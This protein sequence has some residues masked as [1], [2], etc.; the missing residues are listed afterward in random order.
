MRETTRFPSL[1]LSKAPFLVATVVPCLLPSAKVMSETLASSNR[2]T[3]KS[4]FVSSPPSVKRIRFLCPELR[5]ESFVKS[6]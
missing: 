4:T 5:E 3:S 2:F 1:S 6:F